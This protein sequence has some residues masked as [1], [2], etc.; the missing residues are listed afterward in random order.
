MSKYDESVISKL[1]QELKYY[2]YSFLR[3]NFTEIKEIL[4][5]IF[6]PF[7]GSTISSKNILNLATFRIDLRDDSRIILPENFVENN[8]LIRMN[9]CTS[10][11]DKFHIIDESDIDN[12]PEVILSLFSITFNKSGN[13]Y[14]PYLIIYPNGTTETINLPYLIEKI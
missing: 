9:C 3:E 7:F 4:D 5:N 11:P 14:V 12:R 10:Y 2:V 6:S 1:P 13:S 8:T